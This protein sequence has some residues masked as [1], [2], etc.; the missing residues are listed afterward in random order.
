MA[1]S[2]TSARYKYD[3]I[4][5]API[6]YKKLHPHRGCNGNNTRCGNN[7]T[8]HNRQM[9]QAAAENTRRGADCRYVM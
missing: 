4:G 1:D 9:Q 6:G 3:N 8:A 7:R 5:N 2:R